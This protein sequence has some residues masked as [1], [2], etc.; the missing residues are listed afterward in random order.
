MMR[1]IK[2]VTMTLLLAI[3]LGACST[4]ESGP[5]VGKKAPE[6]QLA[7]LD[8]EEK[9]LGDFR[10]QVIVLNFWATWCPPCREE[11]PALQKVYRD[12][13]E[14]G[15]IV[16]GVNLGEP[17]SRVREFVDEFGV[18]FPILLDHHGEVA[19]EYRVRALPV[20]FWI[21]RSGIIRDITIGGPM[22]EEFI[23]ENLDKL[24][25]RRGKQ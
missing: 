15:V 8:G 24:L 14:H 12:M 22:P 11:M 13:H 10:G 3:L 4:P 17:A 9:K 21:D 20:T 19:Q 6:F 16:V 23:M 2:V 5:E 18:E 25:K 7:S 1:L